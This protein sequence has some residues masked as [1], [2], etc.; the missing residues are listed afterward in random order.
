ML[1]GVDEEAA[2][3]SEGGTVGRVRSWL[4]DTGYQLELR[5]A[6]AFRAQGLATEAARYYVAEDSETLREIDVVATAWQSRT[7]LDAAFLEVVHVVECK[8]AN[9]HPWVAFQGDER[10]ARDEDVL[11]TLRVDRRGGTLDQSTGEYSVASLRV[12]G[13]HR[14]PLLFWTELLAYAITETGGKPGQAYNAVRQVLSAVDG[15]ARDMVDET[16]RPVVR[17]TV[18]IVVTAAPLVTCRLNDDGSI[19]LAEV[20]R[21]LLVGRF[22]P[23]AALAGVWIVRDSALDAVAADARRGVDRLTLRRG[24]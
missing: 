23:A 7:G 15:Y 14:A 8:G 12:D 21:V 24:V 19:L 6:A 10:F 13:L 1:V 9:E 22:R 16:T 11:S 5:T 3:E 20:E 17:V 18:P 4:K 2:E